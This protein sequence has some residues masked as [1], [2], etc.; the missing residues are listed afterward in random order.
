M[1]FIISL[2]IF[3]YAPINDNVTFYDETHPVTK[4]PHKCVA[5]EYHIDF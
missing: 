4:K 1:I 2:L 5:I 3:G